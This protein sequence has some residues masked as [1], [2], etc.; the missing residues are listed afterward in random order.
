MRGSLVV[1]AL[2]IL[3]VVDGKALTRV[4]LKPGAAPRTLLHRE[5]TGVLQEKPSFVTRIGPVA[6][7]WS[8]VRQTVP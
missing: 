3:T 7:S 5:L 2:V 6:T 8:P 1:A 4:V